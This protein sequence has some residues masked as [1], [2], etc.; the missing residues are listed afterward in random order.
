[1]TCL[2][3]FYH[4]TEVRQN[5]PDYE[6]GHSGSPEINEV[7][8]SDNCMEIDNTTLEGINEEG[9]KFNLPLHKED[10]PSPD[11]P[12]GSETDPDSGLDHEMDDLDSVDDSETG[13]VETHIPSDDENIPT[14]ANTR[15]E[16]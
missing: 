3:Y 16:V 13:Q 6:D 11:G 12:P 8:N 1:M 4:A 2:R 14:G 10:S 15:A 7:D 5:E 9:D